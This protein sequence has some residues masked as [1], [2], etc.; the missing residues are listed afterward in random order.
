MSTHVFQV[1]VE[2]EDDLLRQPRHPCAPPPEV[3]RWFPNDLYFAILRG[4]AEFTQIVHSEQIAPLS[5]D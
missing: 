3:P 4:Y 2:V 1:R 5:Q